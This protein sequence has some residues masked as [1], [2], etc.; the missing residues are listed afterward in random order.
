MQILAESK[1]STAWCLGKDGTVYDV[2]V[3][4]YGAYDM[5][6]IEDAAWLYLVN[7]G[8]KQKY[9]NYIA[10]QLI[11]D[12]SLESEEDID[13]SFQDIKLSLTEIESIQK[14]SELN[15]LVDSVIQTMKDRLLLSEYEV[16]STLDKTAKEIKS[17]LNNNFIRVRYGSHF[18]T[19]VENPGCLYFRISS[20]GVNWYKAILDFVLRFSE[21]NIIKDI[22]IEKDMASTGTNKVY[23][24]HMP[25][26]DFLFK[27][28][29]VVEAL[30]RIK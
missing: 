6:A 12:F 27:K 16:G 24:D 26:E 17:M 9:V 18:Q 19:F 7:F 10:D 25:F 20:E 5:D 28:P 30:N 15:S 23:L 11:N 13:E 3:H 4:P 21:N 8:N 2:Y 14:Y 22:T 29:F 1:K